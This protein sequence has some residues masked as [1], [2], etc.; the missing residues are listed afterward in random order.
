ME[1]SVEEWSVGGGGGL[2]NSGNYKAYVSTDVAHSGR[3]SLRTEIS[4]PSSPTSGVRAFRWAEAR[5]NRDAY[6]SIWMYVPTQYTLTADPNTGRFWNVFQFKS[7][8]PE[9]SRNDPVWALYAAPDGEG[10]LY[11]HAGWGWGGT[12][13]AGPRA[14]DG[15]GGKWFEPTKRT[16]IPVGRWVHFEAFLHQSKD[17]DGRLSFWQDGEQLFDLQGVR[18]SYNNCDYNAWCADNEWSANLYSDGMSPNP[19]VVYMDDAAISKSY[20]P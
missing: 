4:S 3:Y 1:G 12:E 5:A 15:V 20:I 11:L 6:Y 19:A 13:L 2:Y 14:S 16:P 7:R 17:F 8:T 10:R 9:G 18:T